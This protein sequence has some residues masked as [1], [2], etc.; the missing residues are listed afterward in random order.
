MPHFYDSFPDNLQAWALQQSVF[1]TA[2][3]PL[4]GRHVNLSPK[5][6]PAATFAIFNPNQAGY[7]DF[8]GSGAETISHIYENGRVTVMFCSFDGQPRILRLFCTGRVVEWDMPGFE[9]VIKSMGKENI[10]GTRAV[11]LLDIWKVQ[12]SCGYSVPILRTIGN[13]VEAADAEIEKK[14]AITKVPCQCFEERYTLEKWLVNKVKKKALEDYQVKLNSRSL[15]GLLGLRVARKMRGE[16][17][18]TDECL[19]K[20][21]RV[22][23]HPEALCLGILIGL[24]LTM[25]V[26]LIQIY[27]SL[28]ELVVQLRK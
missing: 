6:R 14:G 22:F 1:F 24:L 4:K 15:D 11:I 27:V 5:G 28:L 18:V 2:S 23:W 26:P 19:A 25:A 12:T 7:L 20:L 21:T 17:V 9:D 8:S 10:V 13:L 16:W 3:A